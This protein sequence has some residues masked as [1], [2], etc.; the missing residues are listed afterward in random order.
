MSQR[1][2]LSKNSAGGNQDYLKRKK[3]EFPEGAVF[4][5]DFPPPLLKKRLRDGDAA[6]GVQCDERG[7]DY[8]E[9]VLS[10]KSREPY[11]YKVPGGGGNGWLRENREI[12]PQGAS[13]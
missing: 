10:G 5:W 12:H 11:V 7:G 2:A 6:R 3:T 4:S 9:G 8:L 13:S 1:E